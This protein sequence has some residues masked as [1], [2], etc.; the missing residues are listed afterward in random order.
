MARAARTFGRGR[1]GSVLLT[2]VVLCACPAAP[3]RP[4][5]PLRIAL[6]SFPISLDP[7]RQNEVFTFGVLRNLYEGLT[8]FDPD[9]T[10]VPALA[11][12]WENPSDLVWRFHLRP[13]V[14]FHDGRPL[15][16]DDV[17][18]SLE[19]ARHP[20][21]GH[22]F[23][24]YLVAVSGVRKIDDLTVEV[25]TAQPYPILLNKLTFVLI[26]PAGSPELI[27][28]AV[29]TG[30]YRLVSARPEGPLVL[31]VFPG[32][33]GPPPAES[34]V[35][36]VIEPDA[37][38]RLALLRAGTVD[39]VREPTPA[40]AL[41]VA[42]A[43]G[44]RVL[45]RESLTVAC[46]EM[47]P[48]TPPFDDARVRRA[49][50]LALDRDAIVRVSQ[51]G[52]ARP[53]GQMVGR[54]AFGFDADLKPPARDVARARALLAEA[55]HPSGLDVDLELRRGRSDGP[56]VRRQLAEAGIRARLVERPWSE[57]FPRLKSEQ[58]GFYLGGFVDPSADASDFLDAV[59]HTQQRARGY[60]DNN[61]LGFSDP[62]L[63]E[64]I[65][66]SAS[67]LDMRKRRLQLALALRRTTEDG[68][69]VPLYAPS[70]LAAVRVDV[71]WRLR[72]DGYALASEMRRAGTAVPRSGS[73]PGGRA[74]TH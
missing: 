15:T 33:W 31:A 32:Y 69:H 37:E 20:P 44:V 21:V 3:E 57:M 41:E 2:V 60:G 25:T 70:N 52:R 24:S 28:T 26:V 56:E 16:A 59:A 68:V 62:T 51:L 22:A 5:R 36:L 47:K 38:R 12:S 53:L 54:M 50:D 29:G 64:L 66:K 40:Q 58:V 63:D 39:V 71:V 1:L 10:L 17:V 74:T 9:M 6:H 19:R 27:E 46:L 14:H 67:T 65:E 73:A 4:T 8:A 11:E 49:V 23:G 72:V 42:G 45:E 43:E 35:E 13:G 18:F 7:H 48:T 34:D 61:V 30:P 55:G